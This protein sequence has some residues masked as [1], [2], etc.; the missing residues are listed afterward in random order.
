MNLLRKLEN[1]ILSIGIIT[2]CFGLIYVLGISTRIEYKYA[3]GFG[4]IMIAI[5]VLLSTLSK[6]NLD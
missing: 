2:C 1:L 6:K 5:S 4:L 3:S